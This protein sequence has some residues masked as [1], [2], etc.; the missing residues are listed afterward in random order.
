MKLSK[1]IK[2]I[3]ALTV[4][5]IYSNGYSTDE[6]ENKLIEWLSCELQSIEN[7]ED[8]STIEISLTVLKKI[9]YLDVVNLNFIRNT[10]FEDNEAVKKLLSLMF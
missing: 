6:S 8:Y 5:D 10:L 2:Q 7:I 4:D 3:V 1:R 9:N